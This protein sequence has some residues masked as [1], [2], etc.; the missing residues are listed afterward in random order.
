MLGAPL[1][2]TTTLPDVAFIGTGTTILV[3]FQLVGVPNVPLNVTVLEPWVAP[4]LNPEI[5]IA[6]PGTATFADRLIIDGAGICTA[7]VLE[8]ESKVAVAREPLLPLVTASPTSAFVAIL[9]V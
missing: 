6:A 3:V 5:V 7:K 4:K 9:M 2:V 8:T 1:T